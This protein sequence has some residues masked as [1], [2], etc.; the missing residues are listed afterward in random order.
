MRMGIFD[1]RHAPHAASI[2]LVHGMW[3]DGS[4]WSRVIPP[5]QAHGHFVVAAQIPLTSVADDVAATRRILAELNGPTI[6]VGHS[7]GGFV[8]SAAANDAAR[9]AGLVFI[10]AFAPEKGE[11]LLSLGGKFPPLE[12]NQ[13]LLLDAQGFAW[14]DPEAFPPHFAGDVEPIAARAMAAA[15]KPA[16]HGILGTQAGRAAWQALPS[17]Y[18]VAS[19]DRMIRPEAERW[20]ARRIKATTREVAAS[21]AAM[22]SQPDVVADLI[23]AAAQA[24]VAA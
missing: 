3:A 8:I 9:V 2:V 7:Y 11:T 21:H 15:Q 1:G 19:E 14:I 20:M 5:L 6:L 18:L 13:H 4:S 22:V 17:W 23:L 12:V 24:V 10:A 16:A